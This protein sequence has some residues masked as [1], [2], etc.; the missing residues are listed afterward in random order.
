[1]MRNAP[2]AIG[3]LIDKQGMSFTA[4]IPEKYIYAGGMT[5]RAS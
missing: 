1:M 3:N 2:Q 5:P 4:E